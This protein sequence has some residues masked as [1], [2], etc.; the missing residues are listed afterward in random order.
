MVAARFLHSCRG[1]GS[2]GNRDGAFVWSTPLNL[3]LNG[4]SAA[5]CPLLPACL[6]AVRATLV[7]LTRSPPL[8]SSKCRHRWGVLLERMGMLA[9]ILMFGVAAL[10]HPGPVKAQPDEAGPLALH[11]V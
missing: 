7:C 11:V 10:L 2:S 5:A 1:C 8:S 3:S 4:L 9:C 6:P